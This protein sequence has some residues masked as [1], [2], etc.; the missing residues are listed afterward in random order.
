[1]YAVVE[2]GGKQVRVAEGDRLRVE[3][4]DAEV[5]TTVEL[6][7]VK[8][9]SKDDQAIVGPDALKTAKVVC[10]ITGQGRS[11]KIRVFKY[12]KR[13]NYHRTYGHRQD[14]TEIK[15]TSIQA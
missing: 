1:M 8:M 13:K 3:R 7:K 14:Y 10:E 4:L 9:I 11:K 12:K 2:T 5:G 15:I 6:D